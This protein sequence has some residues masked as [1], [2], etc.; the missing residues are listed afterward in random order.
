[1]SRFLLQVP[2]VWWGKPM[3]SIVTRR[4]QGILNVLDSILPHTSARI[5]NLLLKLA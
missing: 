4:L 3:S 1:M 5:Q 2:R